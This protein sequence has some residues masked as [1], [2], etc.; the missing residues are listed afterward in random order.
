M[1][2]QYI[3]GSSKKKF[4]FLDGQLVLLSG[5]QPSTP[6]SG[7]IFWES[8]IREEG[9]LRYWVVLGRGGGGREE[10][11]DNLTPVPRLPG[12]LSGVPAVGR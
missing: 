3:P 1:I 12:W 6:L 8:L 11:E 7:S 5:S 4:W 10:V 2:L 9:A